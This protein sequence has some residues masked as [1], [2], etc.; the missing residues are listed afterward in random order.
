M[1]VC[2]AEKPSVA[3]EIANVLG[4]TTKRDGF[5]EGNN[6]CVTWVF[7]HLCELKEPHDYFAYWKK[8]N[9]YDLPIIP[10]K[11]GI[12]LKTDKG[13]PH[14]FEV[15]KG[16][17]S[18]AEQVVNCGDAGQEGELIQRWVMQMAHVAC[19]VKRLWISSLTE[20]SIRQGFAQLREGS[21]FD[22]LYAAG[23]SRAIGDWLLGMNATRAYTLKYSRPGQVLSIGRVQTPTLALIVQRYNEIRN[24]VP[25]TYW[26]LKTVYRGITFSVVSGRFQK[27]EDAEVALQKI[28]NQPFVVKSVQTKE[29]V[30]APPRLYDLT[31]LQVDCNK[32]YAFSADETLRLIQSLYEKKLTTYPRVDT[33]YLS[34]DIYPK[35]PSIMKG[36]TPYMN[37]IEPLLAAKI[38]KS[39]KVFD[40][41]KVTDHHA[42][43]PTGVTP[44]SGLAH[45]EKL[46]Y[47]LVARRFIANFYPDSKISTT[48]VVGDV[49]GVGFK[50]VG[51]Q[52]LDPAWRVVFGQR[53]AQDEDSQKEEETVMPDFAE[54]EQGEHK[55]ALQEKQTTPPKPYTEA[56]LL[57][58]ME[59]AGK[60]VDDEELRD[61]MKDNGIGRPSTRAAI[62]ETLFK[63]HYIIK[64][65]KNL[66]PTI[67]GLQLIGLIKIE[68]L[69]SVELTGIWE[70]K[71]RQI[72]KGQ[73]KTTDFMQEMRQMVTQVVQAVRNDAA[74]VRVDTVEAATAAGPKKSS[75]KTDKAPKTSELVCPRCGRPMLKGK[76][77]WGCS[78]YKEGCK[79]VVPF[80]FSGK[81]ITES[82]LKTLLAK[83][84]TAQIKGFVVDGK[85]VGG[86]LM[87]DGDFNLILK[88]TKDEPVDIS[89]LK[90][91]LCG[92][93]LLTGRAAWGCSNYASGCKF[94][95]PFEFMHKKLTMTHLS[96]LAN[97]RMTASIS[98]FV[99][100][101]GL[102]KSGRLVVKDDGQIVLEEK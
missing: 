89:T 69:K 14:Q 24:F 71:L 70:K 19:P 1:I 102:K 88:P 22:L 68:L 11:F 4:A 17:I 75:A 58:A 90:C 3:R 97:K 31:S 35:I 15:I 41:S 2:I 34:D 77:A 66:V 38:R 23:S 94:C 50:S 61:L 96:V 9:M 67:T 40:N 76:A 65:K 98:G 56:T 87:F 32:K 18:R 26:E 39:K 85:T 64:E 36:L 29:G 51:K 30:E 7:G 27:K 99:D 28:N 52:I 46:V 78:G 79:M 60:Q 49:S 43:I 100:E 53:M 12:K 55:P 42:I 62:I 83:G 21:D 101:N 74:L 59:T 84:E 45:N 91:P 92:G 82:Q 25:E 48:T 20:E 95:V 33:T 16:L 73:Y 81:K 47:D 86:K 8:W 44:S 37:Y 72:E 5:L 54:G 63:R 80:E 6:Y 93:G 13:V 57:R 10:E